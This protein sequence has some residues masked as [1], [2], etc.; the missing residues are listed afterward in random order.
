MWLLAL[1][2]FGMPLRTSL[3]SMQA[4][5]GPVIDFLVL[6][7]KGQSVGGKSVTFFGGVS[8]NKSPLL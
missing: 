1:D 5:K 6:G 7:N 2:S 4:S 8:T 3:E